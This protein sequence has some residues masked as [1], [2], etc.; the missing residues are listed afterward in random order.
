VPGQLTALAQQDPQLAAALDR[1]ERNGGT[2][3]SPRD[4]D[5]I[6]N[7]LTS[8]HN[9][10]QQDAANLVNQWE[11]Q[12][13]QVRAQTDQKAKQVGQAA[14]EGISQGA[15]WSFLALLLGLLAAAWCG[16]AGT[17]SLPKTTVVVS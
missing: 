6:I 7:L 3:Q 1:V 8:K 9:L 4:R 11:Q 12:F 2:S 16:W 13:Q 17:A 10:S 15:L 5:Q 14:A